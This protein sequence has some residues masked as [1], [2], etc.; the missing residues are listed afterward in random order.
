MD[1]GLIMEP[2]NNKVLEVYVD[3]DFS[4]NWNRNY[5]NN[6]YTARSRYGYIIMYHGLPI[7]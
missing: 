6:R 7:L 1:K 2:D 5:S 4:R 3:A